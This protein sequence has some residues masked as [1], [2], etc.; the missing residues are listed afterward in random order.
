M[1]FTN[2]CQIVIFGEYD[3]SSSILNMTIAILDHKIIDRFEGHTRN[4]VS[5]I[6]SVELLNHKW[7]LSP[8]VSIDMV[9]MHTLSN[10][11]VSKTIS[12]APSIS[13]LK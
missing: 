8:L 10:G 6:M 3:I 12:S 13:K 9:K 5:V 7:Y 11:M 2:V 4:K 1:G